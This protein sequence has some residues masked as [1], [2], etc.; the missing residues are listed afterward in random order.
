MFFFPF[1]QLLHVKLKSYQRMKEQL[2]APDS[3]SS[4]ENCGEEEREEEISVASLKGKEVDFLQR[5]VI[6]RKYFGISLHHRRWHH[7]TYF[8][9][10]F[11]PGWWNIVCA[12]ILRTMTLTW[13]QL[14]VGVYW[15]RERT[16]P[17][18]CALDNR[19]ASWHWENCW[20]T[21]E[22]EA[23]LFTAGQWCL[24]LKYYVCKI[25]NTSLVRIIFRY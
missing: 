14:L 9:S 13:E 22:A 11:P 10:L 4:S 21:C 1:L 25:V 5:S 2:L 6:Y 8:P 7:T 16:T 23:L 19:S 12:S 3:E 15:A 17:F 20:E 18:T 24:P